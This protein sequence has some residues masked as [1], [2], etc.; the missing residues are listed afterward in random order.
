MDHVIMENYDNHNDHC[1][2]INPYLKS[3][4]GGGPMDGAA[5]PGM[6]HEGWGCMVS[7]SGMASSSSLWFFWQLSRRSRSHTSLWW[8]RRALYRHMRFS[9][10]LWKRRNSPVL[11]L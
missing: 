8:W 6:E 1:L 4:W 10:S 11:T 3:P 7:A 2:V 5:R 9:N